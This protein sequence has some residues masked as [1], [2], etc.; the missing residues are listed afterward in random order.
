MVIDSGIENADLTTTVNEALS[1]E[2]STISSDVVS[3]GLAETITETALPIIPVGV[4][5]AILGLP[6]L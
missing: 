1:G 5:L 4:V 3:E 6:L 2:A